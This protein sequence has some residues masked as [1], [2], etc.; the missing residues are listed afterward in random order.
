MNINSM[1][2]KGFTLLELL[3]VIGIIGILVSLMTVSYSSA[4]RS[5]RD[6]RRKQDLTSIQ[7]AMEQYYAQNGYKYP[8]CSCT[9][10]AT[11]CCAALTAPFNYFSGTGAA[12]VDPLSTSHYVYSGD[13]TQYTVKA[14][15]EKDG[16]VVPVTNLQ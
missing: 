7:N 13:T 2:N 9:D 10:G 16:S 1:K 3:V 12:P 4:Q 15:M 14:T 5:A 11:S 8:G 6:S